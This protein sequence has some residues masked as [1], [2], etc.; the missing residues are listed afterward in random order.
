M[1]VLICGLPRAGKTT[2]SKAYNNVL[3][4]DDF[5]CAPIP[6][7]Y[8]ICAKKVQTLSDI[9]VDGIYDKAEY[10]KKL[11]DSYKG[12]YTKC[13]WLDTPVEIRKTRPLYSRRCTFPFEPPTLDEGWDEIIIIRGDYE[14]RISK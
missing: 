12:D 3:H 1:L 2:M 11:I 9:V 14:Q 5:G 6:I 13:I 4:C 10:R 7:R 8:D